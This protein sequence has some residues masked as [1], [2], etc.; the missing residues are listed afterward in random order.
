MWFISIL[1]NWLRMNEKSVSIFS[2]RNM[3]IFNFKLWLYLKVPGF[4][5]IFSRIS[6]ISQK[7]ETFGYKFF[8]L[9]STNVNLPWDHVRSH[10]KFGPNQFSRP[11]WRLLD[12]NGQTDRQ[13]N[14]I[15]RF[16]LYFIL[17]CRDKEGNEMFR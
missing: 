17:Y 3:I 7:S 11:F 12:T 15:Y 9:F 10:T 6:K 13:A 2:R 5:N 14:Y 4:N 1:F 8:S 16:I